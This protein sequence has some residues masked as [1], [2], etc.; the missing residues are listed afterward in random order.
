MFS[1]IIKISSIISRRADTL[2]KNNIASLKL[3]I[4]ESKKAEFADKNNTPSK[5]L[6]QSIG[7]K[8]SDKKTK[9]FKKLIYEGRK[10]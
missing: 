4:S 6:A 8:M 10:D 9:G 2:S 5:R 1:G 7:L 3:T